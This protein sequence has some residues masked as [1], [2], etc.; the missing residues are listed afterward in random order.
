ML[1]GGWIK[2]DRQVNAEA[3]AVMPGESGKIH[4]LY[5]VWAI[6]E[7]VATPEGKATLAINNALPELSVRSREHLFI[8]GI[9][10][11]PGEEVSV[12]IPAGGLGVT[13]YVVIHGVTIN[14]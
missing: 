8:W 12:K 3:K 14:A 7:G 2:S 9:K 1:H 6:Y 13:G 5:A 10:A 4:I 11:A